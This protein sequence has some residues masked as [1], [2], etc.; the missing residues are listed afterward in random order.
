MVRPSDRSDRLAVT[1][2]GYGSVTNLVGQHVSSEILQRQLELLRLAAEQDLHHDGRVQSHGDVISRRH[3]GRV[4]LAMS[5]KVTVRAT[6]AC[7]PPLYQR[8]RD[9]ATGGCCCRGWV[10]EG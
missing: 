5:G 10:M 6:A 1:T 8:R 3:D 4:R 2:S 9:A 7:L